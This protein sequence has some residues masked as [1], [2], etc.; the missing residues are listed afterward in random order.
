ARRDPRPLSR[1][2]ALPCLTGPWWP[3]PQPHRRLLAREEGPHWS[4]PVFCRS[5]SAVPAHTPSPHGPSSTSDLCV[6]L[7]AD[8]ASNLVGAAI[9]LAI[10]DDRL[11][12]QAINNVF[13]TM[14]GVRAEAH[15]GKA[16]RDVLGHVAPKVASAFEQVFATGQPLLNFELTAELP[17]RTDVGYWIGSYFPI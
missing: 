12:Y 11:R 7:V 17:T 3:S 15:L 6:S 8:S 10:C 2:G 13:A 9:G 1:Q 16:L 4:G 5:A 14:N